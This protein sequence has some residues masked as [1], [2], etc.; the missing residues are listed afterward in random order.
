MLMRIYERLL[1]TLGPRGWWPVSHGLEPPEWEIMAGAVLTQ[2][3]AWANVER[4]MENLAR[5]GV[6]DRKS[7]L[8]LEESELARLIKPSGYYN[9]KAMKLRVLAGFEGPYTREGLLSLWGIGPETADSILLYSR[10]RPYFVVDAYTRR[11]FTRL[12]LISPEWKYEKVRGFFESRLPRDPEIYKEYHALI[13]EMAKRFC[14]I[15]PVCQGCPM[16][17]FCE[18]ESVK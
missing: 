7:L 12:G 9:Q 4:A 6:R 2:N 15:K 8:G 18:Y 16:E 13:V 10:G 11:I 1:E 14:R 5:A 17:G 3:T